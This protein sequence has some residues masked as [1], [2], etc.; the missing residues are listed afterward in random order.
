MLF[1]VNDFLRKDENQFDLTSIL[2]SANLRLFYQFTYISSI[3][4][5]CSICC[6]CVLILPCATSNVLL[7]KHSSFSRRSLSRLSGLKGGSIL[8]TVNK[9]LKTWDTTELP[10]GVYFYQ[11]L[12]GETKSTAKKLVI[13]R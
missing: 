4:A 3:I 6:K 10:Q 7:A 13:Y 5:T 1:D 2:D 12:Y 8:L 11:I 9:G